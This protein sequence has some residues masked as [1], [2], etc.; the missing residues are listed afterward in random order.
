MDQPK[1]YTTKMKH[2]YIKHLNFSCL[3]LAAFLNHPIFVFV[4]IW[5]YIEIDQEIHSIF[6]LYSDIY[7]ESTRISESS[8]INIQQGLFQ[9]IIVSSDEDALEML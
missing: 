1:I 8:I 2:V 7:I 5:K 4:L 3:N 6:N 9:Y